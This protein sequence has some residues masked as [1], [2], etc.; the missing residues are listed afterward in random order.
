MYVGGVNINYVCSK[1]IIYDYTTNLQF[2]TPMHT[3]GEQ[4]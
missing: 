1:A 3:G 2:A 4:N